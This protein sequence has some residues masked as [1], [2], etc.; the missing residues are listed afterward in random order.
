MRRT[1]P[2]FQG[3]VPGVS[4]QSAATSPAAA[5]AST[6]VLLLMR[7]EKAS[8]GNT[9]QRGP[10]PSRKASHRATVPPSTRPEGMSP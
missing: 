10:S 2:C 7:A 3:V 8:T 4:S 9:G 1:R 6:K 5:S